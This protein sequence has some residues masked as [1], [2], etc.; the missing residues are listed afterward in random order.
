[1]IRVAI[2][3]PHPAMRAGLAAILRE[4]PGIVPVGAAAD[5]HAL[6]PLLYRTDPDVVVVDQLQLCLTVRARHPR[7]RVVLYAAGTGF[8]AVVPA[9]FAGAAAVVD[10]ACGTQELLAAIRGEQGLPRITPRA[11][12]RAAARLDG[13]DKAIFAMRLAGTRDRDI[14]TT[15]GMPRGALAGRTAAILA[16]LGSRAPVGALDGAGEV[17]AG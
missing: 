12:R 10:K 14:A 16:A 9:A 5:R 4:A 1:M 6:L 17:H 3:D 13:T 15:V 7:A 8:D 2:L 11:Q